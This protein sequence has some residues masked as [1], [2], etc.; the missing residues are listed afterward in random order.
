MGGG[1]GGYSRGLQTVELLWRVSDDLVEFERMRSFV[2]YLEMAPTI[3]KGN[4]HIRFV[5]HC[6]LLF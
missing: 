1:G 2:I 4:L 6:R 3:M 5:L